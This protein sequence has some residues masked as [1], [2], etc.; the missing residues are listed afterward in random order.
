MELSELAAYAGEKYNIREE[1]KWVDF[2][3]HSV[4]AHPDTG[5][6]AALLMR[7]WN[8]E[9][10]EEIQCC[11]IRCG[12]ECLRSLSAYG[13]SMPYKMD[14]KDWVGI[15][16]DSRS[17]PDVVFSLFDRAMAS[18]SP[19]GAMII[20]GNERAE[21]QGDYTETP[22]PFPGS[23]G[24]PEKPYI[25]G[26]LREMR[27]LYEYGDGSFRLKCKN[28]YTQGKF[29]EDFEDDAPWNGEFRQYFPVYHDL[30][31]NQLRGYFTWRTQVRKGVYKPV[32]T[33][34]AYIYVYELLNGIGTSSLEDSLL[35]LKEFETG[36]IDSET[37][38]KGMKKNIRRW[39]L[40]LAVSGGLPA[41]KVRE[42]ADEEMMKQDHAMAVLRSPK[43]YGDEEVFEALAVFAGKKMAA[44]SVIRKRETE[45]KRLFAAV[46]RYMT[47]HCKEGNKSWFTLCFGRRRPYVWHP[48]RNAVYYERRRP[49]PGEVLCELNECR[50]FVLQ[51][52]VWTEH[53][54]QKLYFDKGRFDAFVHET[55]RRLRLYLKVGHPLKYRPEDAFAAPFIEAVIAQDEQERIEAARPKITIRLEDLERIRLDAVKTRDSLLTEEEKADS[56]A[57]PPADSIAAPP[58]EPEG[59]IPVPLDTEQVQLLQ[60]LLDGKSVKGL[61]KASGEMPEVVADTLNEALFDEIGD[62]AVECDGDDLVLTEDYRGDII[63]ILGGN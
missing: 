6:W 22:L 33:S 5:K 46:W 43:E 8:E 62:A 50:K 12:R 60:L 35:K 4:L 13:L 16:I 23:P 52:G 18:L 37:G 44:S 48:L 29:M 42:Y 19:N 11:D 9:L 57:A 61:L 34:L 41:E 53:C 17:E 25:P 58:A 14:G 45:G 63:R 40:E 36:F 21:R 30:R 24:L 3:G 54:Y 49:S 55:D 51:D 27:R 1:H 32:S 28:F 59:E 31:L 39:M 7:E 15:K 2:P 26:K 56:I 20:L 10:G 47:D 38:D